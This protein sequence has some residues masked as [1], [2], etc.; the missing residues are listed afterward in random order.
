MFRLCK[1]NSQFFIICEVL[2]LKSHQVTSETIR[3]AYQSQQ[4][5]VVCTSVCFSRIQL[6]RIE[7]DKA[8]SSILVQLS[9]SPTHSNPGC[10]KVTR[11][12][13]KCPQ[14]LL[15]QSIA[16]GIG[17]DV[18]ASLISYLVP[19]TNAWSLLC[20]IDYWGSNSRELLK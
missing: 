9:Q 20:E 13:S 1:E 7:S 11:D 18:I 3:K 6:L 10:I 16:S 2:E 15:F 19:F 14:K 5:Y 8:V 17:S 12:A 4:L